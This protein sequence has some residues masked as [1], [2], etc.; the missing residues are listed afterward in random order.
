MPDGEL[1]AYSEEHFSHH[2]LLIF[3]LISWY[4]PTS[5]KG[6]LQDKFCEKNV[7]KQKVQS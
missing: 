4:A 2:I 7:K 6:L 5:Q 1:Q 3:L